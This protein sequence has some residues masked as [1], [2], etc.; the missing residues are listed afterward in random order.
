MKADVSKGKD[1]ISE[2]KTINDEQQSPEVKESITESVYTGDVPEIDFS[3]LLERVTALE[4]LME[5]LQKRINVKDEPVKI[6][7]KSNYNPDYLP[8]QGGEPMDLNDLPPR[9]G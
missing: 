1:T 9:K 6:P 2:E 5:L 7:P 4:G 8:T 3:D